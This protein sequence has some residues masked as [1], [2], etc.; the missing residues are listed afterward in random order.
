M[1]IFGLIGMGVIATKDV[2]LYEVTL[3]NPAKPL[4]K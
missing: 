2:P 4:N 3:V 1:K